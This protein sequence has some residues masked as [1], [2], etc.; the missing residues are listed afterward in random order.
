M[1]TIHW[2]EW[3]LAFK[4]ASPLLIPAFLTGIVFGA[5]VV[6]S[7]LTVVDGLVMSGFIYSGAAQFVGLQLITSHAGMTV[8][9]ATTFLL[10]LRFF[11]YSVSLIDEVKK[12][13]VTYRTILA[14]GL[15]DAVFVLAKDRFAEEGSEPEKNA[16]FMACVVIFYVNW[17]LGT[18]I[19]LFVGDHLTK[20]SA[21]YGLDFFTYGTFA[22]MLAPYL[23]VRRNL[24]VSLLAFAIYLLTWSAPYHLGIL[25]SCL[26][27]TLLLQMASNMSQ[28]RAKTLEPQ[29]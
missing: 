25:V 18:G 28:R 19:G 1:Q 24:L 16:F 13:P 14:F 23:K 26:A 7:G 4:R 22:A 3:R 10:S 6:E 2:K 15:I 9:L 5:L 27:A 20:Y 21:Q 29:E 12:V 8:A 17:V 11:L